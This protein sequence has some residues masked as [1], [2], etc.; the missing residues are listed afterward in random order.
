MAE[1]LDSRFEIRETVGG[2]IVIALKSEPWAG[3]KQPAQAG[4]GAGAGAGARGGKKRGGDGATA[5]AKGAAAARKKGQHKQK[6][7]DKKQKKELS[8]QAKARA[9]AKAAKMKKFNPPKAKKVKATLEFTNT[10]PKGQKKGA[11]LAVAGSSL[12]FVP[13]HRGGCSMIYRHHPASA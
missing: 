13:P 3:F 6:Q 2:G 12:R 8:E 7:A 9:A 1:K 4:A 5:A 10:T 11:W